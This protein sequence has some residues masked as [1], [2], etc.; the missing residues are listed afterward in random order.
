MTELTDIL[1]C[2]IGSLPMTY[3]GMPL[4]APFKVKNVW[5]SILEK[6]EHRLSGWKKLNL[7]KGR[8]VTLLKSTLSS[9]SPTKTH[10]PPFLICGSLFN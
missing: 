10:L 2:K 5:N 8:R 7:S 4:E 1:C 9:P 3:L 6:M